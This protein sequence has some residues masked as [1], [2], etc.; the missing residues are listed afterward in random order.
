MLPYSVQ[1]TV[2]GHTVGEKL[3]MKLKKCCKVALLL[4]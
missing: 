4:L 3:I 1:H 2:V